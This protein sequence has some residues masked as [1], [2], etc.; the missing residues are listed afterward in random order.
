MACRWSISPYDSPLSDC[1]PRIILPSRTIAALG[2]APCSGDVGSAVAIAR[3]WS[4]KALP[5]THT[6]LLTMAAPTEAIALLQSLARPRLSGDG[7]RVGMV[8][9]AEL[10][11]IE[12]QLL[13]KFIHRAL[14]GEAAGGCTRTARERRRHG[15]GAHELVH[16]LVI[17]TRVR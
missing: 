3:S 16:A 10:E 14:D 8:A 1:S 5:A 6:A 17:R 9:Q 2:S 15:V 12:A 7:V 13:G 11:G 4:R